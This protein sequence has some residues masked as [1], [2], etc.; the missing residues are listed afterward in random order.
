MPPARK[1][2]VPALRRPI[3]SRW[4]GGR[5]HDAAGIGEVTGR[6]DDFV[7]AAA[8]GLLHDPAVAAAW[9]RPSALPQF[10][11]RWLAGQLA[12]QV[13]AAPPL[14]SSPAPPDRVISLGVS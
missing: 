9:D 1:P 5:P 8:A 11:V 7:A 4:T 14:L 6:R 12:Y 13:L 2:R 3:R 10:G